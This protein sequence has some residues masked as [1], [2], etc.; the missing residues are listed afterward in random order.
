MQSNEIV[1]LVLGLVTFGF[2]LANRRDLLVSRG[3]PLLWLAFCIQLLSWLATNLEALFWP[4]AWNAIEHGGES[5]S[6][7]FMLLWCLSQRGRPRR[8]A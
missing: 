1:L 6:A 4:V 5:L 2:M 8:G 3:A 7:M